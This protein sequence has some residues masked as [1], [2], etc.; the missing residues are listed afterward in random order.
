MQIRHLEREIGYRPG[1]YVRQWNRQITG[2]I[3][4][5][6]RIEAVTSCQESNPIYEQPTILEMP[7][8]PKVTGNL[9]E[10]VFAPLEEQPKQKKVVCFELR[11]A[12]T[13]TISLVE[14]VVQIC[15]KE[16]NTYP[17]KIALS[18]LR[19]LSMY[20][21]IDEIN[22]QSRVQ[23]VCADSGANYDVMAICEV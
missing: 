22:R 17:F 18:V 3:E 16:A 1:K 12:Q 10:Q 7:S 5:S 6:G 8:M 23:L 20:R 21:E 2:E 15:I 14:E 4:M 13:S 11:D 19:Y 9:V